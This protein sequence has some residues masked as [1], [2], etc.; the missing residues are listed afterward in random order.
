MQTK[1]ETKSVTFANSQSQTNKAPSYYQYVYKATYDYNNTSAHVSDYLIQSCSIRTRFNLTGVGRIEYYCKCVY[2]DGTV[3]TTSTETL[4]PENGNYHY[5]WLHFYLGEYLGENHKII[6]ELSI[7]LKFMNLSSGYSI[8][9]DE[10]ISRQFNM[11]V[12]YSQ[13]YYDLTTIDCLLD[14]KNNVLETTERNK[15]EYK[16]GTKI[17]TSHLS[18][19]PEKQYE[20]YSSLNNNSASQQS[21]YLYGDTTITWYYKRR[22]SKNIFNKMISKLIN[23]MLK[24]NVSFFD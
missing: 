6:D 10:P 17:N 18:Q 8:I 11:S 23:E 2:K 19:Y 22:Y 4:T 21:I 12:Y 1:I 13:L 7:V 20:I 15:T 3:Y 9:Q 16:A 24:H 14:Y 5:Y